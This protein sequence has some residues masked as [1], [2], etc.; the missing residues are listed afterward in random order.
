MQEIKA[1]E[2]EYAGCRFRSRLEARWAVFLDTLGVKW[3]YEPQGY[4]LGNGDSYLPD[5]WL[6]DWQTWVE[7]KGA[8]T[9]GDWI[10]LYAAT[11]ADG[12]PLTY[13]SGITPLDAIKPYKP[14][15]IPSIDR[16]LLL[17]DIPHSFEGWGHPVTILTGGKPGVQIFFFWNRRRFIPYGH[18]HAWP[19]S[20][21]P[22]FIREMKGREL[23]PVKQADKVR[24]AYDAAR[25]ARFEHGERG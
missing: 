9:E 18:E 13:E 3:Q 2:T 19:A 8:P 25:R 24:I 21:S 6:P 16:V 1:I 7:V 17:S 22:E 10:K 12:L 4:V 5:F 11:A 14:W 20:S 15:E 23:L